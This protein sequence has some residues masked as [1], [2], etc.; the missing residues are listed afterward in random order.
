M[1]AGLLGNGER[2]G[3]RGLGVGAGHRCSL[4]ERGGRGRGDLAGQPRSSVPSSAGFIETALGRAPK[5]G[6]CLDAGTPPVPGREPR[7]KVGVSQTASEAGSAA[8][9][10]PARPDVR[11]GSRGSAAVAGGGSGRPVRA[12]R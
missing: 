4:S 11:T 1:R 3:G 6:R 7:P 5:R 12:S 8:R 10:G 2:R 9:S